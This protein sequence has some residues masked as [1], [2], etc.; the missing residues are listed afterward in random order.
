MRSK[1]LINITV[2][3]WPETRHEKPNLFIPRHSIPCNFFKSDSKI[4]QY[5]FLI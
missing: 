3:K 1:I 5:S 4:D 2:L